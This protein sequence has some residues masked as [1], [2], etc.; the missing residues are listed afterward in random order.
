[1]EKRRSLGSFEIRYDRIFFRT[2]LFRILV[3]WAVT[4]CDDVNRAVPSNRRHV[5]TPLHNVISQKIELSKKCSFGRQGA[6]DWKVLY[7]FFLLSLH[8]E[9]RFV[10]PLPT[11]VICLAVDALCPCLYASPLTSVCSGY[12][13][14][15]A[16]Q[17]QMKESTE[18]LL[19]HRSASIGPSGHSSIRNASWATTQK[20]Y[21]R[22][23]ASDVSLTWSY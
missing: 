12:L 14:K 19:N 21:S 4:P 7:A 6:E 13:L 11:Q 20:S 8:N 23:Y 10:T 2:L 16:S 22:S 17:N 5:L 9:S 3:F 1:M 15:S 18:T